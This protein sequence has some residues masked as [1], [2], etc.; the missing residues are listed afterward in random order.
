KS[1]N[2]NCWS[3][4][5]IITGG[6]YLVVDPAIP[7]ILLKIE[8]VLCSGVDVIQVWENWTESVDKIRFINDI[9]F[10]AHAYNVPVILNNEW[11]LILQT[12]ADGVHF[13][14]LPHNWSRLKPSIGRPIL[15]GVTCGNDIVQIT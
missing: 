2:Y 15:T 5:R 14:T 13:D 7:E 3:M 6:L 8:S 12:E 4:K 11:E 1:T 9:S 10:I